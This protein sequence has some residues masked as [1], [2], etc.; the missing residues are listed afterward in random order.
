LGLGHT[1]YDEYLK[2]KG[3]NPNEIISVVKEP[4]SDLALGWGTRIKLI[5]V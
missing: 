2:G 3:V 1:A 4:V 5:K